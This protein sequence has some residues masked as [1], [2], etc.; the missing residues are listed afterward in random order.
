MFSASSQYAVSSRFCRRERVRLRVLLTLPQIV[1]RA[2]FATRRRR[3]IRRQISRLF[4]VAPKRRFKTNLSSSALSFMARNVAFSARFPQL[5]T[6]LS[7]S[8][9]IDGEQHRHTAE[10]HSK[11]LSF[12][13]TQI[14]MRN[15]DTQPKPFK[16]VSHISRRRSTAHRST[17]RRK[18]FKGV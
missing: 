10:I 5:R 8:A 4:S 9:Q 1:A 15:V 7:F 18:T 2:L 11:A 13:S 3:L 16:R 12:F 14:N 6:L 17:R